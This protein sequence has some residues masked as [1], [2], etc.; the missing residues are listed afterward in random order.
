MKNVLTFMLFLMTL[1]N[2]FFFIFWLSLIHL[3]MSGKDEM[4]Y[5]YDTTATN[6]TILQVIFGLVL[7]V[8]SIMA[9]FWY[10]SVKDG[11]IANVGKLTEEFLKER[12]AAIIRQSVNQSV[13][14]NLS[15]MNMNVKAE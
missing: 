15:M 5:I 7:F 9:V 2:V 3:E 12:G 13:K 8:T 6:I 1:G 11:A 14:D 4:R 10:H